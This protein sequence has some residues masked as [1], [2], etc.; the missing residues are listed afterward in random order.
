MTAYGVEL[1]IGCQRI[2]EQRQQE[3]EDFYFHGRKDTV[4][5]GKAAK[6]WGDD[7]QVIR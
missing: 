3:S 6:D 2:L 4:W 1:R 5:S 7:G